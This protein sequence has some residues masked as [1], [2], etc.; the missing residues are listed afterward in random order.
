MNRL[1]LA[2]IALACL[3]L[4]ACATTV[5]TTAYPVI[6]PASIDTQIKL[7]ELSWWQLRFKLE[8]A[9]DESPDLSSHLL[10]AEQVLLPVITEYEDQLRLWRFHRRAGR[11][12]AGNQFS[13]IFL[14][15][16]E[17]ASQ[18]ESKIDQDAFILWLKQASFLEQTRFHRVGP[19]DLARFE[20][21]S[22]K[23]W[24]EAIQRSWPWFIM[25][26]SQ[27]WLKQ[28]QQISQEEGLADSMSYEELVDHYTAVAKTMNGQWRD[29]AQHAYFH[30]LSALYGYQPVKMRSAELK[31][32]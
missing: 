32:F 21:T 28:L 19:E 3:L 30:H 13:L 10:L 4:G 9:E 18:I 2:C 17:T 26:A 1:S 8:W 29:N 11:D 20:E 16:A 15:D 14:S 24:P 7:E 5:Q 27:G 31:Q 25:G 12:S 23:A 6:E 22:D